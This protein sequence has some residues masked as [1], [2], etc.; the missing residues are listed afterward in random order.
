M[1][2]FSRGLRTDIFY[3]LGLDTDMDLHA[4]FGNVKYF[5]LM[6]SAH[7]AEYFAEAMGNAMISQGTP[8]RVVA[9]LGKTERYSMYKVGPVV[10][11]SHGMGGPSIHILLNE[12]AKLCYRAG[13]VDS[14][15]WIRMGTSGGCGVPPGTVV[16]TT[17]ALND[18]VEPY[19]R[20]VQLGKVVKIPTD[21]VD[22]KFVDAILDS[23]PDNIHAVKGKT[24]AADDF[25][26]GQGRLDGALETWY[27]EDDKMAFLSRLYDAGVRNIE[28]ENVALMGFCNRA[29]ITGACVCVT[30]LDRFN[31]DQV[32]ATKRELA[33][34]NEH[35]IDVVTNFIASELGRFGC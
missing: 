16:V 6:G 10:S 30:F 18:E 11:V 13:I 8:K 24:V 3:H 34:F 2:A 27:N 35:S 21:C 31:G 19:W 29:N 17:Q 33:C 7:R 1:S 9:R 26:E 32:T 25:Y 4:I 15:K 12:L 5:V 22:M 28:M 20:C 14:V 23:V